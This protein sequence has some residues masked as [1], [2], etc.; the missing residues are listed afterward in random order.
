MTKSIRLYYFF[1]LLMILIRVA[2]IETIGGMIP[3][4]LPGYPLGWMGILTA[5][6]FHADYAHLF[7]NVI[8]L[9]VLGWIGFQIS[10]RQLWFVLGGI[11]LLGGLGVY[12]FARP[13]WHIGASSWVY[14]LIAYLFFLGIFSRNQRSFL[15]SLAIAI[16]YGGS[17]IG[18]FPTEGRISWESHLYSALAGI[19]MAWY[20]R[21]T[22]FP[23]NSHSD[24]GDEDFSSE[25]VPEKESPILYHSDWDDKV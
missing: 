4:I 21:K 9:I 3:G 8:P 22:H 11:W 20:F 15:L 2:G 1:L 7:S 13:V 12:F 16:L 23:V 25:D 18:L 24:F 14:G 5:P 10:G 17:V 6:F 19:A